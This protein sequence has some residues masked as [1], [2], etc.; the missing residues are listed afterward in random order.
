V[1]NPSAAQLAP[2][3]VVFSNGGDTASFTGRSLV[4]LTA[5]PLAQNLAVDPSSDPFGPVLSWAL[6]VN[7]DLDIDLV[8]LV[9]YSNTTN[10][11]VGS[12]Q[13]LAATA[14][15][16]DLTGPLPL[17]FD[18]TINVRLVDLFDDNAP[19]TSANISS[20]SRAYVN[21]LTPSVAAIPEPETYALMLAGLGALG[22]V[23]RRRK[24]AADAVERLTNRA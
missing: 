8:Q 5:M 4:G 11:E 14:T 6:P 2:L 17:S 15:S 3:S 7:A 18:L 10:L 16:F 22:F 13:V 20:E 24:F 12:R 23:A 1:L 21:Y 19:F 9:F